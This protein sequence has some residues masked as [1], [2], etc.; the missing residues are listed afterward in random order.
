MEDLEELSSVGGNVV[1][2]RVIIPVLYS[3]VA[4]IERI[5]LNI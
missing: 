4:G 5:L 1:F 3:E 2:D